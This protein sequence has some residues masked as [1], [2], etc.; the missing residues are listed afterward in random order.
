[1]P[2]MI[3]CIL[4]LPITKIDPHINKLM[5]SIPLGVQWSEIIT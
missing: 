1:M 2:T 5:Y 3:P 4:N